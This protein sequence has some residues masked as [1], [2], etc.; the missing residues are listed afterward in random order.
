MPAQL[1]KIGAP[2]ISRFPRHLSPGSG[3]LGLARRVLRQTGFAIFW[4]EGFSTF[5][6]EAFSRPACINHVRAPGTLTGVSSFFFFLSLSLKMQ[7][8]GSC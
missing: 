2:S 4:G 6:V 7:A 8:Q 5:Q 1:I 3:S